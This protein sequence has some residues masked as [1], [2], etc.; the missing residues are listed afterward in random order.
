MKPRSPEHME[1]LGKLA[2]LEMQRIND[3][4]DEASAPLYAAQE[5]E[6]TNAGK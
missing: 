6:A 3:L 5:A 4:L 2:C 1:L